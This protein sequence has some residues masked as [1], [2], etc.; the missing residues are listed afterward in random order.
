MHINYGDTPSEIESIDVEPM[1][2]ERK[3]VEKALQRFF[4]GNVAKYRAGLIAAGEADCNPSHP[5]YSDYQ[6]LADNMTVET[7][8]VDHW[9]GRYSDDMKAVRVIIE[10]NN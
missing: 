7:K 9:N 6:Q 5:N 8:E 2:D 3:T 4:T 10:D 1:G